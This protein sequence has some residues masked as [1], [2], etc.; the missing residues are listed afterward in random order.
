MN[1]VGIGWCK[2]LSPIRHEVIDW[3]YADL[4]SIWSSGTY[5]SENRNC[6]IFVH[7]KALENVMCEMAAIYSEEDE[8]LLFVSDIKDDDRY[9]IYHDD[10]ISW[11]RRSH[12]WVLWEESCDSYHKGLVM[13]GCDV[14][15]AVSL[16]KLMNKHSR[17]RWFE[18][19]SN[20]TYQRC[21]T[22]VT[23]E[24]DY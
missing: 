11:N 21:L 8:L 15:F 6:N 20:E 18:T 17:I 24:I 13:R 4:M 1:W 7:Q 14:S 5:F 2:G 22:R 10:V 3:T 12:Y 16:N 9:F 23:S 19:S